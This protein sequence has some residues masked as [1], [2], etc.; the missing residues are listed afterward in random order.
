MNKNMV[1]KMYLSKALQE[2]EGEMEK[3]EEKLAIDIKNDTDKYKYKYK[4]KYKDKEKDKLEKDKEAEAQK[5]LM[6]FDSKLFNSLCLI[7]RNKFD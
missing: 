5:V 1:S 2:L 7:F 4:Y 6:V 3:W